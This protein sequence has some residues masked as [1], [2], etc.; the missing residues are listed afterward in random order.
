MSVPT[1]EGKTYVGYL[2]I[3]GFKQM[4]ANRKKMESVLDRFYRTMYGA[5]YHVNSMDSTLIKMNVIAVSDCAVLFLNKGHKQDVDEVLGLT[6]MLRCIQ[7]V[8]LEFIKHDCP[9]MTTCSISYGDFSY[10]DRK[11]WKH[12]RK[13]CMNGAAYVEAFLD[14]RLEKPRIKPSECRLLKKGLSVNLPENNDSMVLDSRKDY[15]Y[16]YWILR[17]A[18]EKTEFKKKFRKKWNAMYDSVIELL[19]NY[20]ERAR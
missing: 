5:I 2:D 12:V 20:I 11:E 1:Y 19:Q 17:D 3:S 9:F 15:Y 10:K 7:H 13:N 8:N 6:K 14:S 16:F 4:M 18:N